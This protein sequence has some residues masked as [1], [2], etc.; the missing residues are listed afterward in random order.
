M[1]KLTPPKVRYPL[2]NFQTGPGDLDLFREKK[3][4]VRYIT[5]VWASWSMELGPFRILAASQD[6]PPEAEKLDL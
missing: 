6:I 5:I 3:N 4:Q 1:W 2:S